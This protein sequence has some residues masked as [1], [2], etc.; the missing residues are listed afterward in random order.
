MVDL[1]AD[2][3][4]LDPILPIQG[5]TITHPCS[6]VGAFADDPQ[7]AASG[8]QVPAQEEEALEAPHGETAPRD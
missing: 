1:L 3:S 8:I 4:N 5:Y 7:E 2:E 6:G